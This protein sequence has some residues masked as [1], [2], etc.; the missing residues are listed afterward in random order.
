VGGTAIEKRREGAD[1]MAHMDKLLDEALEE[2]FP[3]SDAV[4]IAVD[5]KPKNSS[6]RNARIPT[7]AESDQIRDDT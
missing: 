5:Y 4:S 6:P 2:T 1:R 7:R 3:A